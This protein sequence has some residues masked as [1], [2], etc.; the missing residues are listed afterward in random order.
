MIME[1]KKIGLE[2]ARILEITE[3][4]TDE[5]PS[6]M[7]K[8]IVLEMLRELY[9]TIKFPK[10]N[11]E[12]KEPVEAHGVTGGFDSGNYRNEVQ[13]ENIPASVEIASEKKPQE[14]AQEVIAHPQEEKLEEQIETPVE[15]ALF[16][17]EEIPV[18]T[19]FD[20]KVILSLYGDDGEEENKPEQTNTEAYEP[21][22]VERQDNNTLRGEA[23]AD[24]ATANAGQVLG[25]VIGNHAETLG[26]A[27]VKNNHNPDVAT[28][29]GS[30]KVNDLISSIGIN[31]KYLM[32]RDMFNGDNNAYE[33][34]IRD[35][36]R[37]DDLDEALLHIHETYDWNP[38]SEGVKLLVELLTKKLA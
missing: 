24:I 1:I 14:P 29:I 20:K 9:Q 26:D 33:A 35:M 34:A 25:E 12:N 30:G 37:F 31:D 2:L 36:E 5:N 3:K 22:S 13:Q 7:E 23:L 38:N 32:V 8:D 11:I 27:Y 10:Q 17:P 4:W 18:K 6:E 21:Q 15:S 16:A 19:K 28:V